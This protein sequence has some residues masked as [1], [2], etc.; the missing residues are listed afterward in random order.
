MYTNLSLHLPINIGV[1]GAPTANV[2]IVAVRT[3]RNNPVI[4]P[5]IPTNLTDDI[6]FRYH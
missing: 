3:T 6:L 1:F 5:Q 2:T 4:V